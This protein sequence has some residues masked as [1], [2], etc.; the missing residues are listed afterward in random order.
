MV[1]DEVGE[2]LGGLW[3]VGTTLS[4]VRDVASS[5]R[6]WSRRG[7]AGVL[8]RALRCRVN[9]HVHFI[10]LLI[11]RS[12]GKV[13][14]LGGQ[15]HFLGALS[16]LMGFG[17]LG[18]RGL[19]SWSCS[20]PGVGVDHGEEGPWEGVLR[21]GVGIGG[22]GVVGSCGGLGLMAGVWLIVVSLRGRDVTVGKAGLEG[23]GDLEVRIVVGRSRKGSVNSGEA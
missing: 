7:L 16:W 13:R 15:V 23:G 22:V 19:S 20:F 11:C 5:S 17:S 14:C 6:I 10:A 21:V 9:L 4:T 12:G 2:V 1:V 3:A 8:L 18:F